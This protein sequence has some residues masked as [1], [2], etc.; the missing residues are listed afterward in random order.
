MIWTHTKNDQFHTTLRFCIVCAINC[1]ILFYNDVVSMKKIVSERESGRVSGKQWRMHSISVDSYVSPSEKQCQW[2][3][4]MTLSPIHW[5]IRI[6]SRVFIDRNCRVA[7]Q[8]WYMF[9][10][11][12]TV[13]STHLIPRRPILKQ[14]SIVNKHI[15]APKITN[16]TFTAASTT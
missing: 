9:N 12:I 10:S 13:S 2:S 4:G 1:N 14:S 5:Q 8:V 7:R 11:Q 6:N 16:K 3:W 15:N